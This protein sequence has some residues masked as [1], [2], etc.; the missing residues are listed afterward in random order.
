MD[1]VVDKFL[2]VGLIQHC[3]SPWASAVAGIRT[4]SGGIRITVNYNKLNKLSILGQLPIPR[5]NEVLGKL[6]TGRIIA[7]FDLVSSFHQIASHKNT[8]PLTVFC[9]PTTPLV[10]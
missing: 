7:L 2:A 4:K 8:I 1:A 3:P 10:E 9:T 5:V 6:G